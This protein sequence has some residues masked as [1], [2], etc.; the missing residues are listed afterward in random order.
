MKVSIRSTLVVATLAAGLTLAGCALPVKA[1]LGD[2]APSDSG[3][4]RQAGI[5]GTEYCIQ[6]DSLLRMRIQWRGF[7]APIEIPRSSRQCNS[8]YETSQFD[9]YG[10]LQYMPVANPISW[11]NLI[12]AGANFWNRPPVAGLWLEPSANEHNGVCDYYDNPGDVRTLD[13]KWFHAELVRNGDT[14]KNKLFT[15]R[16]TDGTGTPGPTPDITEC[17][18]KLWYV[19]PHG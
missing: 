3:V 8:G 2:D 19:P 1:L 16:I 6:N 5:R 10:T 15:L 18:T 14:E 7:P 13:Q 17:A 11:Q 4:S 9:V 12:V